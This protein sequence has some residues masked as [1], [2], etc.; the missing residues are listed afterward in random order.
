MITEHG[1]KLLVGAKICLHYKWFLIILIIRQL[2]YYM[3]RTLKCES[4]YY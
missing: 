2:V 4:F 3:Q 1:N